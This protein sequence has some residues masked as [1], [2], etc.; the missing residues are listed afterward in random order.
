MSFVNCQT[1][2]ESLNN[3]LHTLPLNLKKVGIIGHITQK[4]NLNLFFIII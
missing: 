1:E 4:Y 3:W 2:N